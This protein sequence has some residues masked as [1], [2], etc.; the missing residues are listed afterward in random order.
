[1]FDLKLYGNWEELVVRKIC[2]HGV[3][4]ISTPGN[5]ISEKT[6]FDDFE[7]PLANRYVMRVGRGRAASAWAQNNIHGEFL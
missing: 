1:M 4:T 2:P 6:S 7:D 3:V 5:R